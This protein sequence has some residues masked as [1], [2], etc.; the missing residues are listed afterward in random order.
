MVLAVLVGLSLLAL[1]EAFGSSLLCVSVK[2]NVGGKPAH[3]WTMSAA[4][5]PLSMWSD[6]THS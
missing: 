6:S 4:E 5:V 2:L 1:L 3:H